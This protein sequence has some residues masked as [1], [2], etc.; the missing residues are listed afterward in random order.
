MQEVFL[1]PREELTRCLGDLSLRLPTWVRG[2]MASR[3]PEIHAPVESILCLP[4]SCLPGYSRRLP[5]GSLASGKPEIHAP[6]GSGCCRYH[7]LFSR[8]LFAVLLFAVTLF[9]LA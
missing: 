4:V 7:V 3:R 5:S 9:T 6:V 8:L 2:S 1:L